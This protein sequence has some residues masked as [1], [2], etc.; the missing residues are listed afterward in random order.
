MAAMS[1]PPMPTACSSGGS[2]D[3]RCLLAVL[4]QRLVGCHQ[5]H[6]QAGVCQQAQGVQALAEEGEHQ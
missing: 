1:C 3:S 2:L 4:G 5:G 6:S